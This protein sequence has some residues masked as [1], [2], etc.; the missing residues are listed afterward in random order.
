M[1]VLG[2]E[3]S[4]RAGPVWER[5][6]LLFLVSVISFLKVQLQSQGSHYRAALFKNARNDN[7]VNKVCTHTS[8]SPEVIPLRWLAPSGSGVAVAYTK[9]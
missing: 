2:A 8:L 4:L 7:K 9:H 5:M 3:N 6:G 1:L